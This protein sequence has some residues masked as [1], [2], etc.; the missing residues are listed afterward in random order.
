V[1]TNL[2]ASDEVLADYVAATAARPGV[3]S[4]SLHLEYVD[5]DEFIDKVS[6]VAA[7][8][9]GP[10]VT[11]CVATRDNLPELQALQHRWRQA[12]LRLWAQPEKQDRDVIAYTPA[13][14]AQLQALGG[15][16]GLGHV[17]PDLS[18][19]PCWAG[20]R[21]FIVD[22][23]GDAYRCYPARRTRSEH[24]GNV[25]DGSLRLTAE[26]TACRYAYCN[27]TVPQGRGMVDVT[28]APARIR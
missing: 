10:V 25:L 4:A 7:A 3:L 20:A 27:C 14:R 6:R 12:G 2:S 8:H 22:H 17:D 23:R 5:V 21:Y 28:G 24:L 19:R 9:A 11:T 13:E 15:H 16:N 1:V 18:G 26:T